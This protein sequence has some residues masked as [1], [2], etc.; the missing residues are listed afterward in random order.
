MGIGHLPDSCG[1]GPEP[2]PKTT[3]L[4][5]VSYTLPKGG[6]AS[7]LEGEAKGNRTLFPRPWPLGSEFSPLVPINPPSTGETA[8]VASTATDTSIPVSQP[9]EN[10]E[11]GEDPSTS[12][13]NDPSWSAEDLKEPTELPAAAKPATATTTPSHAE[14]SASREPLGT[15]HLLT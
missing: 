1:L 13:P 5:P 14:A 8:F 7:H 11:M 10:E 3:V 4:P 15:L 9:K 6:L 2:G 12:Q